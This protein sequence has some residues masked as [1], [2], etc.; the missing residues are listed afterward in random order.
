MQSKVLENRDAVMAMHNGELLP[1][2][3]EAVKSLCELEEIIIIK[4]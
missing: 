3:I 1:Q 4:N 2:H